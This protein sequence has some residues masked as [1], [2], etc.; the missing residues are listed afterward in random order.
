MFQL[1]DWVWVHMRKKRFSKH[2]KSKLDPRGY[3]PFQ[4]L[5]RVN[6]NAYKIYLLGEYGS[7]VLLMFF[8]SPFDIGDDLRTNPHEEGG[9]M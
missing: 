6:D 2:K 3:G 1:E 9:M 4:V 7:L 5:D 8:F